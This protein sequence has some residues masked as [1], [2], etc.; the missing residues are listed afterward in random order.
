MS[1]FRVGTNNYILSSNN[2][3]S[4]CVDRLSSD[5]VR[6]GT[7]HATG[8]S[9][10]KRVGDPGRHTSDGKYRSECFTRYAD[11]IEQK[12]GINLDICFKPASRLVTRQRTDSPAFDFLGEDKSLI[13]R[14][15]PLQCRPQDV[16]SWIALAEH[17]MAESDKTLP[18]GQ[19]MLQ[20]AL[21]IAAR[22]DPVEHVKRK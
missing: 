9:L 19:G 10:F 12:R 14:I 11:C 17:P 13:I 16:R 4:F 1:A 22:T 21:D 5:V 20:P 18:S 3:F 6:S 7:H 15:E 8:F 2:L